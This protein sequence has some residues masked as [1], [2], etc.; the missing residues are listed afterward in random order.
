LSLLARDLLCPAAGAAVGGAQDLLSD[1]FIVH[2][3]GVHEA[4]QDEVALAAAA[5]TQAPQVNVTV[6]DTHLKARAR[7]SGSGCC[8]YTH[9]SLLTHYLPHPTSFD[10]Q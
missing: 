9:M 8:L 6:D 3:P 1:T 7:R 5:A 10:P 2:I 4:T